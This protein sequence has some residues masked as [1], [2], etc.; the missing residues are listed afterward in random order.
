MSKG[1]KMRQ[2]RVVFWLGIFITTLSWMLNSG[3]RMLAQSVPGAQNSKL[4]E[5]LL[6]LEQKLEQLEKRLEALS[7]TGPRAK[8]GIAAAPA[9]L[10]APETS[11]SSA[12]GDRLEQLDQKV[13]VLERLRELEQENA[14]AKAKETAT[15]T[16]GREGFIL[17]SSNNDYQLKV[18][19][20]VQSDGQFYLNDSSNAGTDTF[21]MRRV[22]PDIQGT[23]GKYI[24]FRIL[25][26]FGAGTTVLQDAYVDLR[27]SPKLILRT[28]KFKSPVGLERLQSATDLVFILRALP[29]SLAPNRDLGLQLSGDLAQGR[30]N[31]ALGVFN[32]VP[33]G[34]S[35]DADTND[36][37]DFAARL[38]ATPFSTAKLDHPLKGLGA[39]FA[40]T[41]G[42]QSGSLAALKSPG[43]NTYF[44][45]LGGVSADGQRYRYSPQAYYYYGPF[46]LLAEFVATRQDL[47]KGT[48][49]GTISRNAWQVAGSY[50][51]T[52]EHKSFKSVTP[53]KAFLPGKGGWGAWEIAARYSQLA[54]DSQAFQFGFADP[55]KSAR[56]IKEWVAGLNWYLNRNLRIGINYEDVGFSGGA[57]SGNR[58]RERLIL[59]R[60]QIAF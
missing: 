23:V 47:R 49:N 31:Y 12:S 11:A 59:S 41:S 34:G 56:E 50:L 8:S 19:G 6:L 60:F 16:A 26:D 25:P 28:G 21:I 3:S 29:T 15:V 37:K 46:G 9:L 2:K 13:K 58:E 35:V 18:G 54:V 51:L 24:N 53:T 5:R 57:L 1:K 33:D 22:R 36:G 17:K 38:F 45:Y 32:G 20:Y 4:E 44:S 40:V 7:E 55:I 39:G 48:T 42:N 30:L 52:G 27:Y 14:V 43:Q 10:V